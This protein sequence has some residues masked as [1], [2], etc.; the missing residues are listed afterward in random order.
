MKNLISSIAFILISLSSIG[1]YKTK[2]HI[3]RNKK[4]PIY[5]YDNSDIY[6]RGL[7]FKDGRLF[8]G[9]SNGA[10]YYYKI[11]TGKSQLLF[12]L[13]DFNEMRDIAI[14]GNEILGMHSGDDGKILKMNLNG[15]LKV[16][17]Q[18]NWSGVFF[19]GMD[20][21]G[22]IGFIM[23]DPIDSTFSLFKTSDAG[24]IWVPCEGKI[25]AE[26]G[27]AGFAASG[28][29]VQILNDSTF[30]FVSGGLKSRFFKTTD[31]GKTWSNMELPYYPGESTGAYSMHFI[32]DSIGVI[33]GGDYKDPS[34]RLN[35]SF[36]TNDGGKSWFNS[37]NPV[38]GYRSC[39]TS[40]NGVYYSCGRN[41]IDFSLNHGVDWIPF[42]DGV[43]FSLVSTDDK[44]VASM[45]NGTLK[46]FDLITI[47]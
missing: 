25:E 47:E 16:L 38:R 5:Q 42:A 40:K 35:V 4:A 29:N 7:A 34:I 2:K 22:D 37:E 44:L 18:E 13:P 23:G 28:T 21:R 43:F 10:L 8:I 11:A 33:V 31:S 45:K 30:V 46:F 24:K 17:K 1:Q 41:G 3:K 14:V 32:N 9:N 39:V 27:E 26:K 20:F 15:S 6:A 12:K 36:Y 19:D